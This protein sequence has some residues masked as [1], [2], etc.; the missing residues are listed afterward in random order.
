M[1]AVYP[2]C[3][4]GKIEPYIS[5]DGYYAPCCWIGNHPK[6]GM[7]KDFLG[8]DFDKLDAKKHSIA[9]IERC[10]A[11]RRIESSWEQGTLKPCVDF[12][13]EPFDPNENPWRDS[14]LWIDL[15]EIED[16]TENTAS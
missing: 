8:Q 13:G 10:S 11:M 1:P 3:K 12:C 9:D 2:R 14:E 5:A 7:L 15:N 6:L 16:E 4:L